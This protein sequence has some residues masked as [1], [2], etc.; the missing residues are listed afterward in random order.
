MDIS[1]PQEKKSII[2]AKLAVGTLAHNDEK[3]RVEMCSRS[4]AELLQ[5]KQQNVNPAPED[6][7]NH[8]KCEHH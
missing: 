3:S 7:E 4:K 1:Q 5:A 8:R 6:R 2:S